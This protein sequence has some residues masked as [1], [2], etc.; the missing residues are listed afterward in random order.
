MCRD[1]VTPTNIAQILCYAFPE[2]AHLED[3]DGDTLLFNA[4][5]FYFLEAVNFLSYKNP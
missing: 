4:V 2:D 3:S 5:Q 1:N